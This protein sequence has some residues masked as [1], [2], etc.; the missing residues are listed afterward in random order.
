[1]SISHH[2][3]FFNGS[4]KQPRP[5]N[6]Q[7]KEQPALSVSEAYS[8]SPLVLLVCSHGNRELGTDMEPCLEVIL[9][10]YTQHVVFS[11]CW[12]NVGSASATLARHWTSIG[13]Q[14][15]R[16]MCPVR[17]ESRVA[18]FS[19]PTRETGCRRNSCLAWNEN[20]RLKGLMTLLAFPNKWGFLW[21]AQLFWPNSKYYALI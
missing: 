16:I 9:C 14:S 12:L 3:I 1:M 15:F 20:Y 11:Q 8:F 4:I 10:I 7:H 6:N 5:P 17:W 21:T 19:L 18:R 13:P 2:N